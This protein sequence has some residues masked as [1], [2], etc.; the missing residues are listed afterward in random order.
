MRDSSHHTGP[1]HS[2]VNHTTKDMSRL[3]DS[4]RDSKP[5]NGISSLKHQNLPSVPSTPPVAAHSPSRSQS[6][7]KMGDGVSIQKPSTTVPEEISKV[8]APSLLHPAIVRSVPNATQKTNGVKAVNDTEYE[9]K[10]Y[11]SYQSMIRENSV[12]GE[13][14]K[15]GYVVL[16]KISVKNNINEVKTQFI[17]AYN[18]LGI[19]VFIMLDTDGYVSGGNN[20][21]I[22]KETGEAS[23]IPYD[24]KMGA[25]ECAGIDI[26][27]VAFDCNNMI[28]TLRRVDTDVNP[29][30]TTFTYENSSGNPVGMLDDGYIAYP[31]IKMSEIR[32]NPTL[33]LENTEVANQRLVAAASR[34]CMLGLGEAEN[35]LKE[36]NMAFSRFTK[37]REKNAIKL[38]E[39]MVQ[40]NEMN[41]AYISRPPTT[42][43]G[44]EKYREVIYNLRRRNDLI[45]RLLQCCR[46]IGSEGTRFAQLA[47]EVN[48]VNDLFERE[49]Y[50]VEGVL[51]E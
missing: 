8:K 41:K 3:S 39:T 26:C 21:M 27:G 30:E 5:G 23:V 31:I 9:A 36:L 47:R 20:D 6:S 10:E 44:K 13:L 34:S 33:V 11:S 18:K 32:A 38:R 49:F 14:M 22:M 25:F 17:R 7:T 4:S 2:D 12:E 50:G 43:L 51:K 48:D 46:A 35:S 45:S 16:D 24:I 42:D 37:L 19:T 15:A 40:L 28:C 29:R 1:T